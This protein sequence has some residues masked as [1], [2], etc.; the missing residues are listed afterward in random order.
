M[1]PQQAFNQRFQAM[2]PTMPWIPPPATPQ[3]DMW[4][5]GEDSLEAHVRSSL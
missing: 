2:R 5:A 4:A 1:E 3:L